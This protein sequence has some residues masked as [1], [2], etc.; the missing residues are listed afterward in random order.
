MRYKFVSIY[1]ESGNSSINVF[2]F[3]SIQLIKLKKLS[4]LW[5]INI[6]IAAETWYY[7]FSRLK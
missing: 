4:S 1:R 6:L 7:V 5:N 3:I 2:F